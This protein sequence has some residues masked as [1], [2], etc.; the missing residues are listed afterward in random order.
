MC[1]VYCIGQEVRIDVVQLH[2]SG[3]TAKLLVYSGKCIVVRA[4]KSIGVGDQLSSNHIAR[5]SLR[6]VLRTIVVVH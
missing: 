5:M 1:V 3:Y 4:G 2:N 6:R